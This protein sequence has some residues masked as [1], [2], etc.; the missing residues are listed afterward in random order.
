M[1]WLRG[2]LLS[3]RNEREKRATSQRLFGLDTE[4]ETFSS[5]R[6][7]WAGSGLLGLGKWAVSR[8]HF[9]LPET[10]FFFQI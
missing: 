5:G 9:F 10:F 2:S 1:C 3:A 4:Y 7:S 6:G 8:F